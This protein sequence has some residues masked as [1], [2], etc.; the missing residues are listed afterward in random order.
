[1]SKRVLLALLVGVLAV[2]ALTSDAE[3]GELRPQRQPE[4][5]NPP[6]T[7]AQAPRAERPR[8][9]RRPERRPARTRPSRAPRGATR[10]RV[11]EVTDG[12]TVK[13][14]GLGSS[15]LIGVDT[16]EVYFGVECFGRAASAFTSARL[17]PG[18]VV[19]FRRG[20]E[21]T[22]RYGRALV[23][24]WLRNGTFVNALLVRKGFA[25]PLTIPPNVEFAPRFRRLA[26]KA[27]L[28]GRGLW[29]RSTCAGDA[30]RPAGG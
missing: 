16:P 9:V 28:A 29:S 19:H 4:R 22:D 8:E 6:E 13:I 27:R 5:G 11:T 15:R 7:R 10:S 30:D 20:V 17:S 26:R 24:L 1:M 3:D 12:D 23:Y 21:P 25:V 2:V 14:A 18:T